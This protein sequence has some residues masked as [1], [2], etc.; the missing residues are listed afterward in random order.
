MCPVWLH[1]LAA[2]MSGVD[3][4][5]DHRRVVGKTT[6]VKQVGSLPTTPA[7]SSALKMTGA[8]DFLGELAA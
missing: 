7:R 2:K 3:G 6:F 5:M 8:G 1:E 4:A